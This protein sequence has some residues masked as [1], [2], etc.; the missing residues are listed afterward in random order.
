[1]W[2]PYH[3]KQ[4]V[5]QGKNDGRYYALDTARLMP[6]TAPHHHGKV[7]AI[8]I[9]QDIRRPLLMMHLPEDTWLK[10][11]LRI[12][13]VDESEGCVLEHA[14]S[15]CIIVYRKGIEGKTTKKLSAY[16]VKAE[17]E[18][19]ESSEDLKEH[20]TKE[21]ANNNNNGN[22]NNNA[23]KA[24]SPLASLSSSP[25]TTRLR[26]PHP[27]TDT[28]ATTTQQQP[29][30]KEKDKDKSK[31]GSNTNIKRSKGSND[32]KEGDKG[33]NDHKKAAEGDEEEPEDSPSDDD[34]SPSDVDSISE[35]DTDTT[36]ES[37]T[38]DDTEEDL[39][40][41]NF[42]ARAS[43]FSKIDMYGDVMII[44]RYTLI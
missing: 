33:N 14:E 17:K 25:N 43:F 8:L 21:P 42:N 30:Q 18:K 3:N 32:E 15:L 35:D 27:K 29:Q 40:S 6:P 4:Q 22:N 26:T 11:A 9:S 13:G 5:H 10:E 34:S 12:I 23:G 36:S 24:S 16:M 1:M 19:I 7:R 41:D 39:G 37:F 44:K 38:E 20:L 28:T 2:G 31:G